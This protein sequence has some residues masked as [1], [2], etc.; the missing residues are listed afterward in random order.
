MEHQSNKAEWAKR[1]KVGQTGWDLGGGHPLMPTLLRRLKV[2]AHQSTGRVLVPGCGLAHDAAYLA[3]VG[4]AVHGF[5]IVEQAIEQAEEAYGAIK[6]LTL[7]T[8]DAFQLPA[9]DPFDIVFDRAMLC[10]LPKDLRVAYIKSM[11]DQL[12]PGG[13]FAG[14]LFA[15]VNLRPDQ[16]PP[17][18]LS[19]S[20]VGDLFRGGFRLVTWETFPNHEEP[21][22]VE[23]E[24]LVIWQKK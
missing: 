21:K 5:D 22:V 4:Y 18:A 19:E 12:N 1:W 17:F 20:A 9:M 10:A 13:F 14:I 3:K 8:A 23:E 11:Q 2:E 15:K 7:S 24:S 6:N 16:G